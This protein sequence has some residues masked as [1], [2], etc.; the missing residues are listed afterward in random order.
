MFQTQAQAMQENLDNALEALVAAKRNF[1]E[2]SQFLKEEEIQEI[3]GE[4]R[5]TP[6][7][8]MQFEATKRI[9]AGLT[10]VVDNLQG[11]AEKAEIEEQQAKRQK[12]KAEEEV[13]AAD[14]DAASFPS[15]QP[16]GRP[17]NQ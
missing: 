14:G 6:G 10:E 1:H 13:V 5:D 7:A 9:H 2:Q 4:E 16:F 8:D 11:L 15:M 17:G 3:T 12:K